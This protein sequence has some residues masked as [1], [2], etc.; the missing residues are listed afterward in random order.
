MYRKKTSESSPE[1]S[2]EGHL[3]YSQLRKSQS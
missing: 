2:D 1:M 3:V